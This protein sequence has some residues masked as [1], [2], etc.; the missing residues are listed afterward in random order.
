[1]PEAFHDAFAAAVAGDVAALAAW[2]DA[3]DAAAR[4]TV[5]RN[6]AAKGCADALVAQFP[7][8]AKLTGDA[9]LAAAAVA[10]A[11]AF[12]PTQASLLTYG[13][14][15]PAWLAGFLPAE[16]VPWLAGVAALDFLW[17]EAHLAADAEPLD[18]GALHDLAPEDFAAVRLALHPATR[19]AWFDASLPSLWLGLQA[20]TAPAEIA[21]DD[22]P[23]GLAFLR[24]RLDIAPMRLSAGAYALLAACR[25]GLSLAE[26]AAA[27]LA[28]E[29]EL[30][31]AEAFAALIAGGAF[32]RLI[33]LETP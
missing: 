22:S 11:Q 23:E 10:H 18:P 24:P 16:D 14:D 19:L 28:A 30:A 21:L 26:A 9:W 7:T 17:T 33:P 15:F 4:L 25:D 27:A 31:L 12:P 13:A 32:A 5:Y 29:P 8:V 3:P 6:T 20:E 2:T 1:M